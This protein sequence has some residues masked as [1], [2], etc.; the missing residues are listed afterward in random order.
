MSQSPEGAAPGFDKM[1]GLAE[2]IPICVSIPRRGGAWF[3]LETRLRKQTRVTIVSIPRRGGAWFRLRDPQLPHPHVWCL[4]PPRGGAWFRHIE[5]IRA[6]ALKMSQSPEGAAPGFDVRKPR[7]E[8]N[9]NVSIPRRGG[10]WFRRGVGRSRN[11]LSMCLNPPKGR[12]LV[13]TQPRENP[14]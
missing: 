8:G 13:S 2:I 4:N 1:I 7:E 10:A 5:M 14:N 9:N 11:A 6:Q 3:R 12:R